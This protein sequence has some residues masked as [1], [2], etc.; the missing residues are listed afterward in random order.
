M[1]AFTPE[2]HQVAIAMRIP[3][4]NVTSPVNDAHTILL[5][6]VEEIVFPKMSARELGVDDG[7]NSWFDF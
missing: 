4:S 1:C 3:V 2:I 7:G 6:A 5:M